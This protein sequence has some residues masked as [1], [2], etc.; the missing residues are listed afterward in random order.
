MEWFYDLSL[1]NFEIYL[2]F[3]PMSFH[4]EQSGLVN[5]L[6]DSEDSVG[7][8]IDNQWELTWGNDIHKILSRQLILE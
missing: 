5:E 1:R 7:M 3:L 6:T 4:G 2:L 8:M